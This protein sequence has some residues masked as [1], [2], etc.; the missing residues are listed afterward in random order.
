MKRKYMDEKQRRRNKI[1][2]DAATKKYRQRIIPNK[3]L[4]LPPEI[5]DYDDET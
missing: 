3:K 2:R 5:D 4:N 1:A